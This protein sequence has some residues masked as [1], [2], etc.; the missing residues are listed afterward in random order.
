[1]KMFEPGQQIETKIVAISGDTIFIDLN[2]KSEGILDRA[3]L[4]DGN[5]NLTVK[6]GDTLKVFFLSSEDD[7]MHF[8]TK[9]SGD[10]AGKDILES[11][12]KNGIPVEGHVEKEIKGGYEVAIGSSRTFCPYSQMGGRQKEDAASYV[13]KHLTFRIQEYKNDGRDIIVSNRA[14]CE[15]EANDRLAELEQTLKEGMTVKG[16]V[17]SIQSYGAFVDVNGFQALLP[18]SEISHS[19]VE[20]VGKVLSAGQ[21]IT[22]QIIK[23]DWAHERMSLSMKALEADPWD[24]AV[25]NFPVGTKVTGTVS[26]ITEFGLFVTIEPGIDG[27]VHISTLDNVD[28]S[29]N[30][31]KMYKVGAQMDVMVEKVDAGTRRISLKPASSAEQDKT[32]EKYLSGQDDSD[33]EMYSPF[34]ALLKKK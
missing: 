11:A 9:L 23:I 6:E 33:T 31:R 27:L 10:K 24:S 13:G 22:V 18:V 34:A 1:M 16:T 8:T 14:I 32:T 26:R 30:L 12:F 7:E 17:K 5:G 15:A 29:T 25:K 28:R 21:E 2:S 3:E 19:R 4:T 20:D